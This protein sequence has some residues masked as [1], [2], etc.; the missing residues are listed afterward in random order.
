MTV[1]PMT[2]GRPGP[3]GSGA[4]ALPIHLAAHLV[5][6]YRWTEHRLFELTGAWA[7]EVPV[8]AVQVHLAGA[9]GQHAWH[10]ELWAERLPVLDGVDPEALTRPLGPAMGPLLAALAGDPAAAPAPA[11]AGDPAASGG[12]GVVQRLTGLYRVV[13]P[14]LLTSY[15]LHLTRVVPAT[16]GPT[17]RALTLV[18]RDDLEL[19][20]AGEALL[21]EVLRRPH[22]VA[23][24]A[25]VQ[26][27]LE[28]VVV[29]EGAGPGL[30]PWPGEAP[31]G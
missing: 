22:D 29:A 7:A 5:G 20:R 6:A 3:A 12:H 28:S 1:D 24:A 15:A 10:A 30:V 4:T 25:A 18:S 13:M 19:W 31:A 11:P 23:V 2:I 16:D 14:R 26:Q 17:I 8:P 27:R 9:A 21:Q